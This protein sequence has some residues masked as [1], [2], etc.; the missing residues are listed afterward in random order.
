MPDDELTDDALRA[1]IR[2]NARAERGLVV[3]AVVAAATTGL[4]VAVLDVLGHR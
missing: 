3:I 2:A 1:E 4:V